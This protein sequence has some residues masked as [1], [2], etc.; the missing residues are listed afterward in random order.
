MTAPTVRMVA[1]SSFGGPI[2]ATPSGTVYTPDANGYVNSVLY[3]DI[4]TLAS[5]GFTI[6][7]QRSNITATTDPGITNDS[8]Q[9]YAVGSVWFNSTTGVEWR[10]NSVA[11]GAAVWVPQGGLLG[12]LLGANMNSTADQQIP[13]FMPPTAIYNV[14]RILVTNA[15]TSLTTAAGGVYPAAAKA[16]SALVAAGQ[17][18]TA[19]T[20]ATLGLNLTIAQQNRLAAATQL[21]L[22]LTT[23]QGGAATADVYVYG[24]KLAQ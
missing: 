6:S 4:N 9:D 18:Y 2:V 10:A 14:S 21:Y 15:S 23:P 17:V 22:S 11:V 19:L 16:G 13:L 8:T 5:L 7:N 3:A 1:P 24:E 12:R 20:G